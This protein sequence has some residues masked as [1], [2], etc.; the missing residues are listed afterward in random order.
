MIA[1]AERRLLMIVMRI[2]DG[3]FRGDDDDGDD[4][5]DDDHRRRITPKKLLYEAF[6]LIQR[7]A[8]ANAGAGTCHRRGLPCGH[9]S[10]CRCGHVARPLRGRAYG[11]FR[12]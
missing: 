4:A 12:E 11:H 9:R 10:Q 7:G 6:I 2:L 5:A 1:N 8:N 3:L